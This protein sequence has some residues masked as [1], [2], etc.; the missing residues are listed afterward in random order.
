[1]THYKNW[2]HELHVLEQPGYVEIGDDTVHQIQHVGNVPLATHDGQFKHMADVLHVPTITKNLVSVGQMVEQGLQVK[3][4]EH[5]C[6]VED[7][8][9]N[10]RLVA[11]GNRI[12]RMFTLD[13]K[14]PTANDNVLYTQKNAVI[15]DA[16]IWHKRIGHVNIQ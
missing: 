7:L 15:A 8:K 13:V 11:K 5:G 6:Y 4:N 10:C 1:M 2:F 16:D 12:G 9:D 3:F 14:M